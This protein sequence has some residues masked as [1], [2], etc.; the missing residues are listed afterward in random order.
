MLLSIVFSFRNEEEVLEELIQ[1]VGAALQK[2]PYEYEIIFVN[3]DSTD[4]SLEILQAC[5]KQD[6][7]IRILTMSRCFGIHPC[8]LAGL[9]H[10][11]GDAVVYMDADLQ[12]PPEVIPKL[13]EEWEKGA[14]VVHTTRTARKGEN[15]L[16]MFLTRQAYRLINSVSEIKI[17]SN[18]G[19]FKLLSR[20]AVNEVIRLEEHNPF[21]RGL[22]H[23]IGFR[24]VHVPYVREARYAGRTHFSLFGPGPARELERGIIT[25]SDLPLRMSLFVGF[26]TA[27]F[28]F[29]YIIVVLVCKYLQMNLPGWTAIMSAVLFL[30]G[31]VLF[32]NGILGLYLARVYNDVKK[33]PN[34][35]IAEKEGFS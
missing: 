28:S 33:R 20:R 16:K 22:V 21:M 3:D 18:T 10:A 2:L 30:N 4:R 8:V 7:R 9:K 34:Y 23:W 12:D 32:T 19:D 35:I 17:P 14:D 11:A 1:R 31:M 26:F 29:F 6:A 25:F 15:R 5:R 27:F 13:V 24:Q